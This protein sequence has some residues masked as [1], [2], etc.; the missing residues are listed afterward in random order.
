MKIYSHRSDKDVDHLR[1]DIKIGGVVLNFRR[2]G[3][4]S[5]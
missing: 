5:T 3:A 2:S 1:F 4:D